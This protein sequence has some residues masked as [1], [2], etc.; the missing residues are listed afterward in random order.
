MAKDLL[1]FINIPDHLLARAAEFKPPKPKVKLKATTVAPT[2]KN[3]NN[4]TG[5][6]KLIESVKASNGTSIHKISG[7]I[8]KGKTELQ[9]SC[10]GFRIQ[11]KGYCKHTKAAMAKYDL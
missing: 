9:C 8:V 1:G 11:K 10:Q 5:D 4:L 3:P 2:K 6:W 7:R